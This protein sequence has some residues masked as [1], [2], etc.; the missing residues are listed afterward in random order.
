MDYYRVLGLKD[1]ATKDDI[2]KA[3]Y[4][5][6]L[7]SHPDK[8]KSSDAED[9]FK[10]VNE[11]YKILK[12]D[13]KRELYDRFELP[14]LRTSKVRPDPRQS[15]HDRS[16]GRTKHDE[17]FFSGSSESYSEELRHRQELDRI[18]QI[19]TDLLEA[20]NVKR[21]QTSKVGS[22]FLSKQPSKRPA[23]GSFVGDI[24]ANENDDDYEKIV[25]DRL[26]ALGR[27]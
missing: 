16:R 4:K 24:L 13:H 23:V 19:N 11:A 7:L 6:A 12:D 15:Q 26:R 21:R 18:R 3:Y 17:Q 25:L 1:T 10:A 20:A 27:N 22:K 8:N 14:T 9:Q 5:L 2:Q